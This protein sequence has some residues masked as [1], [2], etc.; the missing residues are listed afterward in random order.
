M[1]LQPK[2]RSSL[3]P[4]SR[5]SYMSFL[6][7]YL[8]HVSRCGLVL[9][10]PH[11]ASLGWLSKTRTT[12]RNC[13]PSCSSD[14]NRRAEG[15]QR[16][17]LLATESNSPPEPWFSVIVRGLY[18]ERTYAKATWLSFPYGIRILAAH[19]LRELANGLFPATSES[20]EE[21][22]GAIRFAVPFGRCL[23]KR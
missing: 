21:G 6:T 23:L 19:R 7:L 3:N 4:K 14:H 13:W 12:S 17:S 2:A 11:E 18:T 5:I 20:N 1:R 16:A 15:R 10:P 8:L 9:S 22:T